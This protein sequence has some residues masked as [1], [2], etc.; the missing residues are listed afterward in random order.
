LEKAIPNCLENAEISLPEAFRIQLCFGAQFFKLPPRRFSMKT[1]VRGAIA[2]LMLLGLAAGVM[3]NNTNNTNQ[4]APV[5]LAGG[6]PM[7]M[8]DPSNSS[9]PPPIPPAKPKAQNDPVRLAGGG[10]MPM[11]DPSNSSCPP[12]IPPA[13]PKPQND[14]LLIAGGGPMPMCDPSNSSCPPPIPPAR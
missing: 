3:A 7:P 4:N 5:M 2:V 14:P 8:C 13:N 10:P 11:C 1:V 12:P 6:G 9:C